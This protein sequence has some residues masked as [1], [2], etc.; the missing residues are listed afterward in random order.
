LVE[1]LL[2]FSQTDA[3]LSLDVPALLR[4]ELEA[5]LLYNS[6]T[7]F[8][9]WVELPYEKARVSHRAVLVAEKQVSRNIFGRES[10][11]SHRTCATLE[12]HRYG[13][14]SGS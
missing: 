8:S 11:D 5:H 3:M 9:R 1:D 12:D 6:Y 14:F 10:P 13:F 4:V 7:I 2:R